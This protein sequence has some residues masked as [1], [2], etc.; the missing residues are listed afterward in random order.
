MKKLGIVLLC[1]IFGGGAPS[2][3]VA[4]SPSNPLQP[5]G[6][7][8]LVVG[9]EWEQN[10][11]SL[12]LDQDSDVTSNRY[13]LQGT[14]GLLEWLDLSGAVGAVDF[15]VST[16]QNTHS[17]SFESHHLTFGFRGGL[18]VRA[19]HDEERGNTVMLTASGSHMRTEDFV[20]S[21]TPKEL[22]WNELQT[23]VSLARRYR[24]AL[25]YVGCSYSL[26]DGELTWSGGES[27][28]FQDPGG[29]AFT[30]IDFS[31]PSRYVL[32]FQIRGRIG[33]NWDEMS[34]LIGLS[35]SAK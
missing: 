9:A 2:V 17:F 19:F 11:R 5:I 3:T 1:C 21:R 13:W 23:G 25:P 20:G 27:Q 24:F 14:Y 33:G 18:K 12:E 29:V 16:S 32:S 4:L 30:G 7:G 34:F 10:N 22:C 26:V 15:D 6:K 31:L 8:R 28:D 35:Q